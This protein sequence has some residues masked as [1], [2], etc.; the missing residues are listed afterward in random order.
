MHAI[1][2]LILAALLAGATVAL[3]AGS[4]LADAP[5]CC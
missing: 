1:S 4:V 3:A 2:R 5:A